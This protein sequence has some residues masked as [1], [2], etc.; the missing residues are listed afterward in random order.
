MCRFGLALCLYSQQPKTHTLSLY[1]IWISNLRQWYGEIKRHGEK[2]ELGDR[3]LCGYFYF[4]INFLKKILGWVQLSLYSS[5]SYGKSLTFQISGEINSSS[6]N[7]HA[8]LNFH[9]ITRKLCLFH[10]SDRHGFISL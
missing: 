6:I 3:L 5:T 8:K 10:T 2:K 1:R 4:P 9:F 7:L